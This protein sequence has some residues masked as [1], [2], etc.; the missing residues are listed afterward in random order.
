MAPLPL[1]DPPLNDGVVRLRAW[2]ERDVPAAWRATQD[3][4]I[5]RF[6]RVPEGQTEDDVRAYV[7]AL[8]PDR[9]AGEHLGLVIADPADDLLGMIS[10]LRID[11]DA[12]R[13]EI[14]YWLAPWGRGRGA[15]TRAV[16][17]LAH[18]ALRTLAFARLE[19]RVETGNAASQAVAERAG[20]VR[21]GVLRSYEPLKGVRRDLVIYSL[22]P[23]DYADRFT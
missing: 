1:P 8:E 3:P 10:L 20:F 16:I 22:L 7:A 14:G 21:E 6:T 23:A 19:L 17:L 9:R 5:T 11:W 13:A 4:L 18:W 2:T 12:A 15:A